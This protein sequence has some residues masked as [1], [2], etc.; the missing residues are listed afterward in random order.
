MSGATKEEGKKLFGFERPHPAKPGELKSHE[1]WAQLKAISD[2]PN[3]PDR[4]YW[5]VYD[6]LYDLTTFNHPGGSDWIKFTQG[7]D[8]TEL[9]ESY[10]VN[11]SKPKQL[12]QKYFIKEIKTKRN[13]NSFTFHSNNFYSIFR[14]RVW[15]ILEKCEGGTGPTRQMLFIHDFLL[16][17]FIL[18][19]ILTMNPSLMTSR[20]YESLSSSPSSSDSPSSSSDSSSSLSSSLSS[21]LLFSWLPLS[22]ITGFILQCLGTCC[23]NFYHQK[24]N[25][26]MYSWD[27]TP[28]SSYEWR[29][30]H[31]YSH[32]T[33]P[34]TAYDYEIMIFRP[35]LYF[36]P[37]KKS[38][39]H[40]LFIPIILQIVALVAMHLQVCLTTLSLLSFHHL[41]SSCYAGH[42][43]FKDIFDFF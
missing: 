37:I 38:I 43:E 2:L 25:W 42:R 34:N 11:I 12:L 20:A 18:L 1:H 30:S 29:I 19:L 16:I 9:F 27:L 40:Q 5:R 3:E 36:F 15:N 21:L 14:Q 6:S 22:M 7:N 10:H 4:Q 32:H 17:I 23:H 24:D 26:R 28:A 13:S 41:L 31:A 35:F 33:F 39:L 8:I